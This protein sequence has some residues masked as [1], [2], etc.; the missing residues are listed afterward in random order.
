ML[1]VANMVYCLVVSVN[2]ITWFWEKS[3]IFDKVVYAVLL[4]KCLPSLLLALSAMFSNKK[5]L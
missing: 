5:K 1:Q 4:I 3:I 2:L